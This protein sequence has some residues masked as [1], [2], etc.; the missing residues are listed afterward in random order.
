[1]LFS[2]EEHATLLPSDAII[3]AC[4]TK[5]SGI[6]SLRVAI[7][8]EAE[9]KL[10]YLYLSQKLVFTENYYPEVSCIPDKKFSGLGWFFWFFSMVFKVNILI[11][12]RL[13][14][15]SL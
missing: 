12:D 7:S 3:A 10:I 2:S 6:P 14:Q 11:E 4:L 8:A 9:L 15:F 1:M 5:I 13:L